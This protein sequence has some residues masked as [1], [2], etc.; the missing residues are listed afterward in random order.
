MK[1]Y[2]RAGYDYSKIEVEKSKYSSIIN[3]DDSDSISTNEFVNE[4][5]KTKYEQFIDS[6][7]PCKGSRK[8]YF[9]EVDE[10]TDFDFYKMQEDYPDLNDC[11][12]ILSKTNNEPLDNSVYVILGDS[13][14]GY[15]YTIISWDEFAE[16]Y[17]N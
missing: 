5:S 14:K 17:E 10:F 12:M 2:K 16:K 9:G 11:Y 8:E 6:I 15:D 13:A 7:N 1:F 4:S 3:H